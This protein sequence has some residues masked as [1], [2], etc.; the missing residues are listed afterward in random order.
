MNRNLTNV[1]Q[2][3]TDYDKFDLLEANRLTN[4]SHIEKLK[5]SI[6]ENPV[7]VQAQPILVNEKYEIIDGQHRFIASRELGLPIYFTLVPGLTIEDARNMNVLHRRWRAEDYARSYASTGNREYMKYLE[8]REEYGF[9]H[10]TTLAYIE[11]VHRHGISGRFRHGLMVIQNEALTRQLL[12]QL[13]ETGQFVDYVND[14]KWASALLKA[15][16][17]DNYD[18]ARFIRK[19]EMNPNLLRRRATMEDYLRMIEEVYNFKQGLA[20]HIR[21]F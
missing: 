20:N 15:M 12:D 10:T 5:A 14:Y 19:M 17:S 9:P 18:H 2:E 7:L 1:V 6:E 16:L 21:L 4:R 3:S 13:A 8:L 11:G